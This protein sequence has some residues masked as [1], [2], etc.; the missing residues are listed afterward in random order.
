MNGPVVATGG[1]EVVNL[2]VPLDRVDIHPM[3]IVFSVFTNPFTLRLS[4]QLT[5]ECHVDMTVKCDGNK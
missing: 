3:S 5:G 1:K 4:R 2:W